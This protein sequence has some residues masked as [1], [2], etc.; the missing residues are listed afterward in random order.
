MVSDNKLFYIYLKI[1]IGSGGGGVAGGGERW[2][3]KKRD[4]ILR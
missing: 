3:C 1:I 2:V 4:I